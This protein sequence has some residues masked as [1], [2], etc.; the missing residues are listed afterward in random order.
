MPHGSSAAHRGLRN[1]G[2]TQRLVLHILANQA[3]CTARDLS[4]HWPSLSKSAA[5]AAVNRL[6][7]RGLVDMG[8]GEFSY[9]GRFRRS[10][11]LTARG[12]TVERILSDAG[13]VLDEDEGK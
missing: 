7:D 2:R 3:P 5:M 13:D 8:P 11:V 9:A 6:A 4:Y 12:A 10:F 1:L